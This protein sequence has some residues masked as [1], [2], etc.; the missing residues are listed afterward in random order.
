[1]SR[2]G[3]SKDIC[4]IFALNPAVLTYF[5]SDAHNDAIGVAFVLLAA[6]VAPAAPLI[7]A[8]LVSCGALVKVSLIGLSLVI[9]RTHASLLRRCAYVMLSL[10]ALLGSALN[11]EPGITVDFAP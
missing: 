3:V 1:M 7:A 9:F 4:T 5:V 6:F 10:V 11:R 8:L 2:F